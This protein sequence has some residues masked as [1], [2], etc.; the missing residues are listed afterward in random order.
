MFCNTSLASMVLY[1][2]NPNKIKY[3]LVKLLVLLTSHN[4]VPNLMEH[5]QG[6]RQN[7]PF[8]IQRPH[9]SYCSSSPAR[10]WSREC[11]WGQSGRL[12]KCI[13][14]PS[15]ETFISSYY[16]YSLPLECEKRK[17]LIFNGTLSLTMTDRYRLVQK[18]ILEK[19]IWNGTRSHQC[20]GYRESFLEG[21]KETTL[22]I[23]D[24]TSV[25][26]LFHCTKCV[27]LLKSHF[28]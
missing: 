2:H 24:Y 5:T 25:W 22:K 10:K 15:S 26:S 18:P 17:Y 12:V 21:W 23:S 11:R 6:Y 3:M 27:L 13:V 8:Q 9:L 20:L 28:M 7:S 14:E 16:L 1:K 4:I 19:M